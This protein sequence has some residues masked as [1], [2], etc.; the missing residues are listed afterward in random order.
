MDADSLPDHF[1]ASVVREEVWAID[2]ESYRL[3]EERR[4]SGF[5]VCRS[6]DGIPH[7]VAGDHLPVLDPESHRLIGVDPA[8]LLRMLEDT[9]GLDE[10]ALLKILERFA[11]SAPLR[12]RVIRRARYVSN[13]RIDDAQSTTCLVVTSTGPGFRRS[14]V[15]TE[16]RIEAHL[17]LFANQ[18]PD[19][20]SAVSD[21]RNLPILWSGG[22]AS[23]LFHEA[24]GHPAE[25]GL[26]PAGLPTWLRVSDRP[27]GAALGSM[28]F[29]DCGVASSE[30]D[31]SSGER[32]GCFRRESF[33][34]VPL[35]R[36]SNLHA[37]IIADS[38]PIEL[39]DQFIA[40]RL[41]G[42]GGYDPLHDRIRLSV[43]LAELVEG[44][45]STPIAPFEI[46]GSRE[47]VLRSIIAGEGPPITYPGVLCA[48]DG[49]R[50]PVGS[51]APLLLSKPWAIP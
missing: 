28:A 35:R 21:L 47:Q 12:A 29:D 13:G 6:R 33:R 51:E 36:M 19:P 5:A 16:D 15:C 7:L 8:E 38:N 23:I 44:E 3:L 40:V 4:E 18:T 42:E 10:A 32:P 41:I 11:A 34:S 43:T 30:R 46:G 39:P 14:I 1:F 9:V 25:R 20:P 45:R 24:L 26:M 17:H 49:Q 2:N 37:E 48:E 50:I 22:S 31:L 27:S